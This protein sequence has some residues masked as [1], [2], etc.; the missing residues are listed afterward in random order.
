MEVC[1]MFKVPRGTVQ[2][3]QES[4][5]RFSGMVAAFCERLGWS[6]MEGLVSKFQSRVSFGVKSEIVELT[7]I[8]F[9]K[10]GAYN[11]TTVLCMLLHLI[12]KEGMQ[13][14]ADASSVWIEAWLNCQSYMSLYQKVGLHS[15]EVGP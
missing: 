6:D 5:G 4:A 2:G 1:A 12:D 14:I 3:L 15:N 8:P 10:V 7:E 11:A 13:Y 9:V